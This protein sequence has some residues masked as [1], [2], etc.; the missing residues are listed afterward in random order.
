MDIS[1]RERTAT[2]AAEEFAGLR[3]YRYWFLVVG[4]L[5]VLLGFAAIAFPVAASLAAVLVV[6][7]VLVAAGAVQ[8]LHALGVPAWRGFVASLLAGALSLTVGVLVLLHPWSGVLS[9]TLLIGSFFIAGGGIKIGMALRVKPDLGW[10]WL[11]LAGVLSIA[12]GVLIIWFWPS[13][14][15]WV[16]GVLVGV[17][18]VFGGVWLLS[19]GVALRQGPGDERSR[20][21]LIDVNPRRKTVR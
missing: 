14:A 16:L 1:Q 15:G 8:V 10:K 3:D 21:L 6:G 7:V 20:A 9:L 4:S 12:L 2:G 17:D 19:L 13:A 5:L 11:L 18:I